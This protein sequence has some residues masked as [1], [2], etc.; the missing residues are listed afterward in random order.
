MSQF[1]VPFQ[2]PV[3][4]RFHGYHTPWHNPLPGTPVFPPLP[5]LFSLLVSGNQWGLVRIFV[6]KWVFRAVGGGSGRSGFP[7]DDVFERLGTSLLQKHTPEPFI[8][9]SSVKFE[10]WCQLVAGTHSRTELTRGANFERPSNILPRKHG[11]F[12]PHISACSSLVFPVEQSSR[13]CCS[14]GDM[15]STFLLCVCHV[16]MIFLLEDAL[17]Q[18]SMPDHDFVKHVM[19]CWP[20]ARRFLEE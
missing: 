20:T 18:G 19:A 5:L 15:S 4:A 14:V 2:P 8:D 12:F 10:R 13:T 9:Y 6:Q 1:K 11:T 3:V 17:Q 16:G 7:S